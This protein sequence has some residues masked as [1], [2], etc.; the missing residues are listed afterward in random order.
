VAEDP[1]VAADFRDGICSVSSVEDA[2]TKAECLGE[3]RRDRYP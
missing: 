3:E 2:V 1:R